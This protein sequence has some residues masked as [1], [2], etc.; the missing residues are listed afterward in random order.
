M[1]LKK[2]T[3]IKLS[4]ALLAPRLLL[5]TLYVD[6]RRVRRLLCII[7]FFRFNLSDL[8]IHRSRK[9]LQLTTYLP[10]LLSW[11][12]ACKSMITFYLQLSSISLEELLKNSTQDASNITGTTTP[13]RKKHGISFKSSVRCLLVTQSTSTMS[14]SSS[15]WC[16]KP[17]M[18]RRWRITR[19][20]MRH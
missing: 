9:N 20:Q 14:F 3:N 4:V 12:G 1:K 19:S 13:E 15:S 11:V 18:P 10:V 8:M 16:F 17:M 7:R 6:Q 5:R 2:V